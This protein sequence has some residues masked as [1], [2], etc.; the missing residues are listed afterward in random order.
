MIAF[1]I[2]RMPTVELSDDELRDSAQAA[3]VA[4]AQAKKDAVAQ[5]N[6]RISAMFAESVVR[7]TRLARKFEGA[8]GDAPAIEV[9]S[10]S[11]PSRGG[12]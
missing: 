4:A 5:L 2:L 7:Y 12:Y 8:R 11:T 9:L 3:R 1:Y 6:P 10:R